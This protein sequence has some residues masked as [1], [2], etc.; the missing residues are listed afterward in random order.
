[1]KIMRTLTTFCAGVGLLFMAQQAAAFGPNGHRI[2][3]QIGENHLTETAA[4]EIKKITGGQYLAQLATWPDEIRSDSSWGWVSPW[5]Y[6]SI[7]DDES[8]DDFPRSKDGD[9]WYA[10]E[11]FEKQLR[12]RQVVDSDGIT[13]WQ[14]LAFYIHFTGDIHQPLHVGRR[15]DLGG[16]KIN[17]KWFWEDSNLHKVWDEGLIDHEGLSFREYSDFLD[18]ASDAEMAEWQDSVYLDWAKESK[19]VRAQVYDF[20][21]QKEGEVPELDYGYVFQNHHLI[22]KRMLQAGVRL[23]GMLNVIFDPNNGKQKSSKP[24]AKYKHAHKK[25]HCVNDYR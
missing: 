13:L 2:V 9:A 25:K 3:A 5:H 17:V 7:D 4:A 15:D 23:A 10:L 24:A 12:A 1:M 6:L 18:Q 22:G 20:G 19:A 8:F 21:E 14:A 16:N 11:R